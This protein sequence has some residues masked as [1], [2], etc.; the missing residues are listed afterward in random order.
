[1]HVLV[2]VHGARPRDARSGGAGLA[3]RLTGMM[4][5]AAPLLALLMACEPSAPL[6][7]IQVRVKLAEGVNG[8]VV[9]QIHVK[10]TALQGPD[11]PLTV[12]SNRTP[13]ETTHAINVS[14]AF[15]SAVRLEVSALDRSTRTDE[16]NPPVLATGVVE[17]DATGKPI[18]VASGL[19]PL[20]DVTLACVEGVDCATGNLPP[21]IE[22]PEP[23]ALAEADEKTVNVTTHDP[24]EDVV[25]L[26]VDG[27]PAWITIAPAATA[28]IFKVTLAP[29][30]REGGAHDF[31]LRASD[32]TLSATA[33]LHVDVAETPYVV[34]FDGLG[35]R[36][37]GGL[38][39]LGSAVTLE[40]WYQRSASGAPFNDE[41]LVALY[42]S[43]GLEIRIAATAGGTDGKL[44]ASAVFPG[45]AGA[46]ASAD[47]PG[48]GWHHVALTLGAGGL[49]LFLDG[50]QAAAGAITPPA[51]GELR[52]WFGGQPTESY[53][54][55][56]EL[57]ELRI[58]AAERSAGDVAAGMTAAPPATDLVR[59]Y[60]LDDGDGTT[61]KDLSPSA[62]DAAL[63]GD[64]AFA[65]ASR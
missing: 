57:D 50:A 28:G 55:L 51:I 18:R 5:R 64:A 39:T 58:F 17:V 13:V 25:T 20:V 7:A 38:L 19:R 24:D 15:S 49:K 14:R 65:R 36:M 9:K 45:V 33:A 10:I 40:A 29:G 53:G 26:T 35:D 37:D 22:A 21:R 62:V 8:A 63:I 30:P 1:V 59:H 42:R 48:D 56:G 31:T 60:P 6:P 2:L 4:H 54:F 43:G 32:A 11:Q 27:S 23:V 47:L 12:A 16:A 46:Y 34:T 52:A 61:A 44:T 41:T 3:V